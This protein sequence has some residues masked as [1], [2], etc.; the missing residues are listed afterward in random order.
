MTERQQAILSAI[1]ELY[2]RTAEPVGSAALV[3]LFDMSSATIRNEMATLESAGFI[4]Q[5]H[6]SAGRVP[7]DKGY[8]AYVNKREIAPGI[9]PANRTYQALRRRVEDIEVAEEA[10]KEATAKIA[11]ITGNMGIATLPQQIYSYGLANLFKQPDFFSV[12]QAYELARLV[13]HL[14]D[15]IAE[16]A[17]EGR[18]NVYIGRENPIGKDSGASLII[19]TFKSPFSDRSY[20]GV[21]G[22]T[23]QHYDQV[24]DLVE[25]TGKLL[26]DSL[27]E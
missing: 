19:S 4:M 5:P 27:G 23:R 11:E 16:A 6:I 17:P 8:R 12:A 10:I 15:W 13:D 24:I 3:E 14:D 18:V 9:V 22:P 2:A 7:T 1:V 21:I 25:Y 20:I 26:E